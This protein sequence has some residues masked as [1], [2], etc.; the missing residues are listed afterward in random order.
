MTSYSYH[1]KRQYFYRQIKNFWPDMYG[2]EYALFD[3]ATIEQNELDQLRLATEHIGKIFFKVCKL[4]REVPKETLMEM[5]FPAESLPF[6]KL[7]TFPFE[8]VIARLDLIKTETGYKCIEINSD[9]PTF[10]KELFLINGLVCKEFQLKDPNA[11]MENMLANSIKQSINECA[12]QIQKPKPY[13]VFTAHEDSEEDRET[14][15]YLQDLAELPA[16]FVP[17]HQLEIVQ[18]QGLYDEYGT[19][20]DIL[21]RQTFPIENLILDHDQNGNKIGLWLLELVEVGK[22]TILNPP[23]AFLLQNKAVQAVIWGLHQENHAFFTKEEHRWIQQ[24]FL[25][26]FFEPDYFIDSKISF[27]KKPSFGREGDTVEVFNG[28]GELVLQD[29]QKNYTDFVPVYQQYVELPSVSFRSEKGKQNGKLLIGSFLLN[30]HAAAVGF[31][32]GERITNNLSYYMPL[33]VKPETE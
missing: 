18:G 13:I 22:L 12:K 10:I 8:S 19:K 11:G 15:R 16:R 30:G 4:L 28:A 3:I 25:P 23:S 17:L 29:S 24:Y 7:M 21:Y 14:V 9:T 2:E 1:E 6:L 20:I 32:V 31:R 5:G 33:G 27:V 26:T